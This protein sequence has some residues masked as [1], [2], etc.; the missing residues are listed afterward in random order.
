LTISGLEGVIA[1]NHLSEAIS[2]PVKAVF[3]TTE[4]TE[5]TEDNQEDWGEGTVLVKAV[6]FTTEARRNSEESLILG[7]MLV[8]ANNY[9]GEAI[10]GTVKAVKADLPQSTRRNTE[11]SCNLGESKSCNTP[12]QAHGRWRGTEWGQKV[13]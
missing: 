7:V 3:F 12:R 8:I 11:E 10:S 2:V 9:P 6:F 4:D 1:N 5:N 13:S